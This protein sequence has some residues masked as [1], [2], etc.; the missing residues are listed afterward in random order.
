MHSVPSWRLSR[1]GVVALLL[2]CLLAPLGTVQAEVVEEKPSALAMFGDAILVR[3]LMLVTT[4]LGAATYVVS[5][6]FSLL[7]NNAD[8]AA[9]VLVLGPAEATFVRCLGCTRSGRKPEVVVVEE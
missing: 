1:K 9:E 4:A 2:I 7:G 8:E 6:P 3:P 5:L